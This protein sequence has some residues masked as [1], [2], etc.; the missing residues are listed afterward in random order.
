MPVAGSTAPASV[1][2]LRAHVVDLE[3]SCRSQH[4]QHRTFAS[5]PIAAWTGDH[6]TMGSPVAGSTATE[7]AIKAASNARMITAMGLP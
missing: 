7:T 5:L 1:T 3:W 4:G 6:A 2:H